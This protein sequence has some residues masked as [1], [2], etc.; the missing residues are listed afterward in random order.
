MALVAGH[1]LAAPHGVAK[2]MIDRGAERHV[3]QVGERTRHPR[4]RP[5]AADIGQRDQ[6]RRFRLHAAQH[7]HQR[8]LGARRRGTALRVGEQRRERAIGIARDQVREA[9]RIGAN[10][11]PQIGRGLGDAR[12]KAAQ[13]RMPGD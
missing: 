9:C 1:E 7:P 8:G 5:D 2:Q 12:Q 13:R 3:G 6:Q 11:V 10:E 4:H